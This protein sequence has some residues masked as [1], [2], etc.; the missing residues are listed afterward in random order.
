[1]P[2]PQFDLLSSF[3]VP[4]IQ[5]L[6]EHSASSRWVV[7]FSGGLDSTA[8]LRLLCYFKQQTADNIELLVV[9]VHH[10]LSP[11][12]DAWA[13]HCQEVCDTLSI[14]LVIDRVSV[15]NE[16]G[17]VEDAARRARYGVFERYMTAGSVLWQGHHANDQAETLL[18]R[19]LRGSG[20]DG[21]AGIPSQRTFKAGC[22]VRP[23]LHMGRAELLSIAKKAGWTWI[24][25]ESNA[26]DSYD[27][28]YIR[29][30]VMPE[31]E[32]RW[33]KAN[34]R[35]SKTTNHCSAAR[36]VLNTYLDKELGQASRPSLVNS[37]AEFGLAYHDLAQLSQEHQALVLKR[38]F[39]SCQAGFPGEKKFS[40]IWMEL[41]DCA[42]D[43]QPEIHWVVENVHWFLRRYDNHLYLSKQPRLSKPSGPSKIDAATVDIT[44][45]LAGLQEGR[46]DDGQV[47]LFLD[48][49]ITLSRKP[50]EGRDGVYIAF[51][52]KGETAS[53][54]MRKGGEF[55][56]GQG[57]VKTLLQNAHIPPWWRS[58][59]PL[60]YFGET[61]KAVGDLVTA[62]KSPV[63]GGFYLY[64]RCQVGK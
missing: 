17:G 13:R 44:A 5:L 12:A 51:P 10:G 41:L 52:E 27:R 20:L 24:E 58:R 36:R 49:S 64:W 6:H 55:L 4:V 26:S 3:S 35:L 28:N 62:D 37:L 21:L 50:M 25:D 59:V 22:I 39:E 63:D 19:M 9:H 14:E 31:I 2:A 8:L 7:A 57:V 16:G 45:L 11:N 38:W 48:Q 33:P 32:K 1:M 15:S 43:R 46:G 29:H 61:L 23:L 53:L 42:P 54:R 56:A 47:V 34:A 60:L 40:R 18:L 30:R